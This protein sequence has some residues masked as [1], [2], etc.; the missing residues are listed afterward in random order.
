MCTLCIIILKKNHL[1]FVF[2]TFLHEASKT[3]SI[4]NFFGN[5]NYSEGAL[6]KYGII[7]HLE[8]GRK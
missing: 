3:L 2:T 5:R 6:T 1:Y 7:Q 4:V 8:F